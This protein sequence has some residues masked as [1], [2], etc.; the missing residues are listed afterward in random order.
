MA[1]LI[2]FIKTSERVIP[3]IAPIIAYINIIAPPSIPVCLG[4]V[5]PATNAPEKKPPVKLK[6]TKSAFT[7]SPL[8]DLIKN[9]C[10]SF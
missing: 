3:I 8:T 6:I 5:S 10:Y 7:K 1:G 2:L 4:K 9:K